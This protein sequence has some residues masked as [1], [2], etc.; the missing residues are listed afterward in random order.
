MKLINDKMFTCKEVLSELE[1]LGT[2]QTKK[3]FVRHGAPSNQ[4]FGVKMGDLKVLEKKIKKN[5]HL[6]LELYKTKNTDAMYLAGLIADE[7]LISKDD[8][9]YWVENASWY[10]IGEYTVPWIA[11]ESKFGLELG[12]L[13][14]KSNQEKI[15][16]SGWSTLCSYLSITPNEIIDLIVFQKLLK[17]IELDI[18]KQPNRVRYSMNCF[19]IACG[20]YVNELTN[21]AKQSALTIG[22]VNVDVTG[23]ACKIPSAVEYILKVEKM[24][25]V[26]V[27]KK[28]AR[29]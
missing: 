12:L 2:E 21:L 26:G 24:N 18:H 19:I 23:T 8:L 1:K 10:M 9:N 3:T 13:W 27:K 25:R 16:A 15:A 14:I 5:H 29:C 6:S 11:A 7:K 20:S 22:K 17:Q 28:K 4:L